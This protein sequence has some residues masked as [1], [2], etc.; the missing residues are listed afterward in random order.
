MHYKI[1]EDCITQD[2]IKQIVN[3]FFN[4]SHMHRHTNGMIKIDSPWN[5]EPIK[6]LL[7]PLLSEVIS[8]ALDS[9]GDNIYK[10]NH[11]YFPHVDLHG[12]YPCFNVLIPLKLSNETD[13][14]FVIFDQY[15]NDTTQGRTWLGDFTLP[16][17]SEFESNKSRKFF[18]GDPIV[19]GLGTKH[20]DHDFYKRYLEHPLRSKNLFRGLTGVAI[21]YKPGNMIIF[22]S[23]HI[24][25]TGKMTCEYKMGLS[26]RFKG[27]FNDSINWSY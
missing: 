11:P 6:D 26:L 16:N 25:C 23:K 10:H 4:N 18:I 5:L 17:S 8:I 15:V 21:P 27:N 9:I 1:I 3:Y 13:Q 7:K 20:I 24:H 19:E 14:R 12:S 22:D 2:T